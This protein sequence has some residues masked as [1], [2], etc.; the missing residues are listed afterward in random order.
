MCEKLL[1]NKIDVFCFGNQEETTMHSDG[2][3][4]EISFMHDGFLTI[5]MISY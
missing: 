5:C 1:R 4:I 3:Y 2:K